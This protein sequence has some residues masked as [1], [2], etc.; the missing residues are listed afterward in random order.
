[1]TICQFQDMARLAARCRAEIGHAL[2][3]SRAEEAGG[4]RGGRVAFDVP[5]DVADRVVFMDGGR[6]V[7]EGPPELIFSAPRDPRTQAFLQRVL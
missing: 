7:E 6:I 5:R 1:M 4:Q 2:A 3:G